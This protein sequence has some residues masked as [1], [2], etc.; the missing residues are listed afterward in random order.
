MAQLYNKIDKCR[1]Y[2]ISL[3]SL[4]FPAIIFNVSK[5]CG[6]RLQTA[7]KIFDND[8]PIIIKRNNISR[9]YRI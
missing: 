4:S 7:L 3:F 9:L 1:M 6:Y 5:N 2:R 8:K